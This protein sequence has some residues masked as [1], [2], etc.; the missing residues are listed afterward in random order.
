[1]IARSW[2]A[3]R[4]GA[5][6]IAILGLLAATAC[7]APSTPS[8][9]T[10]GWTFES[11]DGA[12]GNGG[13]VH[14]DVGTSSVAL[15]NGDE[16]DVFYND[17]TSGTLRHLSGAGPTRTYGIVDG[18]GGPAG[19]TADD[20][21]A[22]PSA[23][24]FDGFPHVFYADATAHALRHA[25]W[26]GTFW[27]SE[28]LDGTG[29]AWPGSTT[30]AVGL[31]SS[32]VVDG[33][34]PNVFYADATA[35]TLRHAWWDGTSWYFETLDGSGSQWTGA[36]AHS[37]GASSSVTEFAG[38]PNVFYADSSTHSLRHAWWDGS[39]WQFETL[40]GTGGIWSGG[41]AHA[42]DPVSSVTQFQGLPNL[43]YE[44][45]VSH[46]LRHAWWDG[47]IWQFETLD[48][49]GSAW[50]G[51]TTDQVGSSSSVDEYGGFPHVFFIDSTNHGLRH[52]WWDGTFWHFETLDGITTGTD[53]QVTTGVAGATSVVAT[54]S[55]LHVLYRGIADHSLRHAA[56]VPTTAPIAADGSLTGLTVAP[57]TLSPAFDPSIHDYV[58]SCAVGINQL[59]V[60]VQADP[61][62]AVTAVVD[63][64]DGV[65]ASTVPLATPGQASAQDVTTPVAI[66]PDEAMVVTAT[67]ASGPPVDYWVRCLP[68]DF[69]PISFAYHPGNG[70]PTPGWYLIGN[71]FVS[72][73]E[74]GYAI[75]LDA[76]GTPVWYHRSPPGAV[77]VDAL[78][79]DQI[80]FAPVLGPGFGIDTQ[81]DYDIYS[82]DS[83][84]R[85]TVQTVG[86]PTDLHEFRTLPN[87]DHV[88]L[89]Y[90]VETGVDLT[91]ALGWGASTTLADCVIQE[92]APNGSLV[93]QWRASD[94]FD[95]SITTIPPPGTVQASTIADLFHCNSVDVSGNSVL[96]S[97]RNMDAM[98]LIDKTTGNVVWKIGGNSVA[99]VGTQI[100]SLQGVSAPFS[101][102]HDARFQPGGAISLF[103]DHTN[104]PSGV[105]RGLVMAINTGAG[106]ATVTREIDAVGFNS[107]ATGSFRIAADGSA[108]IG[109]GDHPS[110][111]GGLVFSEYNANN[112][113]MLD[114]TF[115]A[116]N[117][118]YRAVKVP[119]AQL[120]INQLRRTAGRS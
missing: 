2:R 60:S 5:A 113:D 34:F 7:T 70:T 65:T 115:G 77:N 44:D 80:S 15:A 12:G 25:W 55:A 89:S 17:A 66:E 88:V 8:P 108:L 3:R 13:R 81:G 64:P 14:D 72:P 45:A 27:H 118:T 67:P 99:P 51:A 10:Y 22:N 46:S 49:V 104:D 48:G 52:A 75:V 109:W 53:G 37:V 98:F 117:Y 112:Q 83:W 43:F 91:S 62:V 111:G 110:G 103:D 92:L 116:G 79:P 30:D 33:D 39:V 82:L 21:G 29:S 119:L 56:W 41:T 19:A 24:T 16:V 100:L 9:A 57:L 86:M 90:P 38:F 40:D 32:A 50:P 4:T 94:H 31:T 1:V 23:I 20:V 28:V 36:V 114:A 63:T 69:P 59:D 26:D 106:T 102:Q 61:G 97:A 42:L 58:V 76:N 78:A 95:P 105:A 71:T 6:L 11:A 47:S 35:H 54:S 84:G 96:V 68:P 74:A 73:N 87:G 101:R 107:F 120:D 18:P 85:Q 93:W